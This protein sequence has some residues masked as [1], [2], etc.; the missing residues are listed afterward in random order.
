[1]NIKAIIFDK[2][3][4]LMSFDAFWLKV[5][6]N[7][8]GEMIRRLGCN[9]V[10][11]DELLAAMGV[12]NGS[13][14][15]E[16]VLCKGTYREMAQAMHGIFKAHGSGVT[17]DELTDAVVDT[18]LENA[19]TGDVLPTCPDICG[20]LKQLK[21]EGIKLAVITTDKH[22]MTCKCLEKLGIKEFFDMI[23]TDDGAIPPKPAPDSLYDF[24][25]K[26][27]LCADNVVMVGDTMT[28]V[29]F[30]RNA[31]IKVIGVGATEQGRS[32]LAAHADAVVPDISY[33]HGII[34]GGM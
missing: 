20:V 4:T 16:S 27:G 29:K 18:Y 21:D 3:G 9:D 2:D 7:A 25:E 6:E 1:M 17:E 32:L 13:I 28:D 8:L 34:K 12:E 23:Y 19:A 14:G 24:C 15:I 11:V 33:V 5:S 30:A 10:T 26:A 31:G 22:E